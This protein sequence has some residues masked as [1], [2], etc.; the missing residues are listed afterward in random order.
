[1]AER[2]QAPAPQRLNDPPELEEIQPAA[3]GGA[4]VDLELPEEPEVESD[5]A[6]TKPEPRRTS[7]SG[8]DLKPLQDKIKAS[9]EARDEADRRT[10]AVTRERDEAR[11]KLAAEVNARFQSD[12]SAIANALAAASAEADNAEGRYATAMEAQ[13]YKA[14]AKAQRELSIATADLR[15]AEQGQRQLANYKEQMVQQV[16]AQAANVRAESRQPQQNNLTPRTQEWVERNPRF[17]T[18]QT[19]YSAALAAHQMAVAKKHVPDSDSYFE[20][21]DDFIASQLGDG[22]TPR[23]QNTR[24]SA[25]DEFIEDDDMQDEKPAPQRATSGRVASPSRTTMDVRGNGARTSDTR[26]QLS[27]DEKETALNAKLSLSDPG[28]NISDAEALR[29]YAQNKVA[30]EKEGRR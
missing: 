27:Q 12:E 28:E 25:R 1:M 2:R 22:E 26:V 10:Q 3:D 13:D 4:I 16:Q 20:F 11:Q 5:A 6:E 9:N 17:N 7:V 8:A 14:A 19:F 30:L 23:R 18:D 29:R 24:R 21:V 15:Q